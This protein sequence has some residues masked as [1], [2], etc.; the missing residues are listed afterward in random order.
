MIRIAYMSHDLS[1]ALHTRASW[2]D[3]F[4]LCKPRVVALLML[5]ALVG[6]CLASPTWI[7]WQVCILG[8][9]G[10]GLAACSA[11]V[12]NHLVDRH[13]DQKMHRTKNR[14]LVRGKVTPGECVLFASVLGFMSMFILIYFINSLTAIL[15]FV[16]VI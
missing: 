9:L 12:I 2:R 16:T 5:T 15:T 3:F 8:N 4:E 6:M 13:I 14:P 10:I 7:G 1:L 11:A